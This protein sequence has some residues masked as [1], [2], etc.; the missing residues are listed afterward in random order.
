M[1]FNNS[2]LRGKIRENFGSEYA[3]GEA[4]GMAL[5]TLSGKLNNKSEFT[6]SEILSIVKLLNL[7]KEEIYD[8]FFCL[9]SS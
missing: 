5:S 3:F 1:K 7:K 2:K 4:L 9:F 8:V 6:R